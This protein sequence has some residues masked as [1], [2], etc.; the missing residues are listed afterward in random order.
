M[1]LEHN[2]TLLEA[3]AIQH[4]WEGKVVPDATPSS[5]LERFMEEVA[6]LKDLDGAEFDE[7][8]KD[9]VYAK[10]VGYEAIDCVIIACGLIQSLGLDA[11]T[12]FRE[13]LEKNH[14]KYNVVEHADLVRQGATPAEAMAT[15]KTVWDSSKST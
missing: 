3:Q 10:E 2:I 7:K 9:P 6:E 8:C 4:W 15:Q 12:L 14:H 11:E 5:R 1:T 13:K